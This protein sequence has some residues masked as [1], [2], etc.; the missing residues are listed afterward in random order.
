MF[1]TICAVLETYK[2]SN[3]RRWAV[4]NAILK[5]GQVETA[6]GLREAGMLRSPQQND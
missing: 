1:E 2:S 4:Q 6:L 3:R 5:V